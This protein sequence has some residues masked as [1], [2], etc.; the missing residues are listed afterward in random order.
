MMNEQYTAD[1]QLHIEYN[2]IANVAINCGRIFFYTK[3]VF[4]T[5]YPKID[6]LTIV[7]TTLRVAYPSS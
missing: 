4:Q 1:N 7:K 5:N 6:M 2:T 3:P